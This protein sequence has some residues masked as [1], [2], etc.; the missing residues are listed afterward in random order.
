MSEETQGETAEGT[1]GWRFEEE[2]LMWGTSY[3]LYSPTGYVV[4]TPERWL[5]DSVAA[6]Y[7]NALEAR[8]RWAD[9][10]ARPALLAIQQTNVNREGLRDM[11]WH[12][13]AAYPQPVQ[14]QD[15]WLT[16]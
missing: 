12:A 9:E 15:V 6:D 11:A 2:V 10:V 4:S 13:L 8:A 14:G 16:P 1:T 7:L 3:R 5:R